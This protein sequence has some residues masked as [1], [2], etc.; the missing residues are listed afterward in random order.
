MKYQWISSFHSPGSLPSVSSSIRSVT[1]L[2]AV[3]GPG[4]LGVS[5]CVDVGRQPRLSASFLLLS[6][7]FLG[8]W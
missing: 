4:T 3:S 7:W 5:K 8:L 6:G 2:A 1:C